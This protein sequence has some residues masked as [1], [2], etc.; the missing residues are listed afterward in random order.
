MQPYQST[1]DLADTFGSIAE[2]LR[3]REILI[4]AFG[5]DAHGLDN[6]CHTLKVLFVRFWLQTVTLRPFDLHEKT[7]SSAG[8]KHA[9]RSNPLQQ[10]VEALLPFQPMQGGRA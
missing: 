8:K 3:T 10:Q 6:I 5:Y 2:A 1:G 7:G 4:I 9:S